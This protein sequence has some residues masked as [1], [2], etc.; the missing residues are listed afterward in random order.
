[1]IET[2][3]SASRTENK[4]SGYAGC[5][6]FPWCRGQGAKLQLLTCS[7]RN[8]GG[9]L[10]GAERFNGVVWQRRSSQRAFGDGVGRS[11]QVDIINDRVAG[12]VR[13]SEEDRFFGAVRECGALN[14]DL[15]IHAAVDARSE[16]AVPV[17]VDNVDR[18]KADRRGTAVNVIPVVVGI[19][20]VEMTRVLILVAV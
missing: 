20:D 12:V 16:K 8:S 6:G 5:E 10:G 17:V 2:L 3:L 13:V 11:T 4:R 18:A 7:L 15:S 19:R 1:M 9:D 14:Q